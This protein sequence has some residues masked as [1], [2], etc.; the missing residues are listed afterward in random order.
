MQRTASASD[1]FPGRS[2]ARVRSRWMRCLLQRSQL[3]SAAV[4]GRR[5]ASAPMLLSSFLVACIS[6]G[7]GAQHPR[8]PS[9]STSSPRAGPARHKG[10][11]RQGG[12]RPDIIQVGYGKLCKLSQGDVTCRDLC[13][14]RTQQV[15]HDAVDLSYIGRYACAVE[16]SGKV[17]CWWPF[18]SNPK[19]AKVRQ[20]ATRV[21]G[22]VADACAALRDGSMDCWR[23][24]RGE[25]PWSAAK[26]CPLDKKH[27]RCTPR[28]P[29]GKNWA[30]A[31]LGWFGA[32]FLAADGGVSC[33]GP[34]DAGQAAPVAAKWL[35]TATLV[36]L[37]APAKVVVMQ[38]GFSCALLPQ[39]RVFCW[40]DESSGQWAGGS[41]GKHAAPSPVQL[42][43][44]ARGLVM[45]GGGACAL[46]GNDV[47][48]WGGF[49]LPGGSWARAPTRVLGGVRSLAAGLATACARFANGK[50]FCWGLYTR[51]CAK[52]PRAP[53]S[54][55]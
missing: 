32:C 17:V 55:E 14:G 13:T 23:H 38:A 16:R 3:I 41:L 24:G 40:G 50:R 18:L 26:H 35:P 28:D 20:P 45:G 47:Y 51:S 36:P 54:P 21:Y 10:P 11:A 33:A 6:L 52:S 42:P 44:R 5:V 25:T 22:G 29:R 8:I 48:C 4:Q 31:G 37:P 39:G 34:N 1:C 46:V 12:K 43:G 9:S 2:V 53:G 27:V 15:L 19:V 49:Y 30:S 7:C